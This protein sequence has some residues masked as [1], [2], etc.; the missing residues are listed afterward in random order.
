MTERSRYDCS[1]YIVSNDFHA[2][3]RLL[4]VTLILRKFGIRIVLFLTTLPA[5]ARVI[6]PFDL[7]FGISI[8]VSLTG[9]RLVTGR[10][11]GRGSF[12]IN[13]VVF[14]ESTRFSTMFGLLLT[15]VYNYLWF[16]PFG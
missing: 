1:N 9:I 2:Q 6:N 16:L 8:A 14:A 13:V 10:W 5:L 3:A 11:I 15:K 4:T 12:C 7:I